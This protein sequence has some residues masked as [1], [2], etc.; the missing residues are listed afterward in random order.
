MTLLV[1]IRQRYSILDQHV[2]NQS[3]TNLILTILIAV[4]IPHT[5]QIQTRNMDGKNFFQNVSI[6]LTIVIMIFLY[7]LPDIIISSALK[8]L[9]KGV[10]KKHL[11][12]SVEK[13]PMQEMPLPLRYGEMAYKPVP[14]YILMSVLKQLT[15]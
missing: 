12:Q 4:K 7:V 6:L 15:D 5:L 2:C 8:E 3:I 11:L 10:E 1:R 13:S 9:G 14:S